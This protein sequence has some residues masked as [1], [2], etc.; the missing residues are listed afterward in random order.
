MGELLG[1]LS[2]EALNSIGVVALI[3]LLGVALV[4]EWLVVGSTHRRELTA[5]DLQFERMVASKNLEFD[6]MVTAKDATIDRIKGEKDDWRDTARASDA[7]GDVLSEQVRD[8]VQE[9]RTFN[10][11]MESMNDV[12][13]R[14]GT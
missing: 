12:V 11:F 5:R 2:T 4:R 7:R 13:N 8:L 10:H 14:G 9:H 1:T 3:V 6:R